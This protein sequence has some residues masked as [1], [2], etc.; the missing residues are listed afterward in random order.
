MEINL[1]INYY[2]YYNLVR[3]SE[4]INGIIE[5]ISLFDEHTLYLTG[6][7]LR[8]SIWNKLHLREESIFTD[9]CDI[10]YYNKDINKYHEKLIEDFLHNLSPNINWSVKNQA[11]MHIRNNHAQYQN[12]NDALKC[13]PET[14]SSIAISGSWDII[15]PYGFNDIMNLKLQPTQFCWINELEVYMKRVENKRWLSNFP[16]LKECDLKYQFDFF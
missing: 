3:K 14:A 4:L 11:R 16:M 1:D 2:E 5:T 7:V 12:I 10:I 13:F 6:G 8:N 15:A 9:D